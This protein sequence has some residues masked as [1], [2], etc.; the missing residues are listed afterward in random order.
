VTKAEDVVAAFS[1]NLQRY[2]YGGAGAVAN[3]FRWADGY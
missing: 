3:K 1:E 2:R